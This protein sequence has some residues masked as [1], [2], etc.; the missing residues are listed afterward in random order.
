M[1]EERKL[2]TRR[3]VMRTILEANGGEELYFSLTSK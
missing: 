2:R 1:P 3:E